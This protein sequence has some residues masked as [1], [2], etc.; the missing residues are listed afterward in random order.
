MAAMQRAM[1]VAGKA[2]NSRY[3]G[4]RQSHKGTTHATATAVWA[5]GNEENL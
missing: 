4:A 3:R 1:I 5:E 2:T